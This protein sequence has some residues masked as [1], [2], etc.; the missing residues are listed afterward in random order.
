M[1]GYAVLV[2]TYWHNGAPH[3]PENNSG[4][5]IDGLAPVEKRETKM[6]YYDWTFI[7]LIPAFILAL[8][9]QN[10][11]KGTYRKYLKIPS[12]WGRTGAQVARSILDHQ[13]LQSVAVVEGQGF[14]GDHYDP[15]KRQVSLSPDNYRGTSLAALAVS[16]HETGHAIQHKESYVPLKWRT[17][18]YP[19]ANIGSNLAFPLLIIGF[20]FSFPALIDIGIAVFSA[21][22]L[23]QLI[24]LPVE[25]NASS[26]ALLILK[27]NGFLTTQE[28]GGAKKVLDAAALTY[29]AAAAMALIQLLRLL[30]LRN[31]R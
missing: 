27:T 31:E 1:K 21:A 16:A 4:T 8:Y 29:V 7:L 10:K 30:I 3:S 14:L 24:T 5:V 22:V 17:A 12:A 9:A 20:I 28:V 11:V 25:F 6:F 15:A 2:L 13:G 26:R 23:F 18:I 19:A